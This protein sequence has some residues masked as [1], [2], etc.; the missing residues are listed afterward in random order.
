[1][2]ADA[3]AGRAIARGVA[4]GAALLGFFRPETL[5]KAEGLC[6]WQLLPVAAGP[7]AP[8]L[9]SVAAHASRAAAGSAVGA[10]G[11]G[12]LAGVAPHEAAA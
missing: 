6:C 8:V 11:A 10:P 12:R 7:S 5:L 9:A 4:A 1:M 3:V 2:P